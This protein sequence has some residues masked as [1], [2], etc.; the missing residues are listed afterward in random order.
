V[1]K[2]RKIWG[3]TERVDVGEQ[4]RSADLD[5][6]ISTD[7]YK[8]QEITKPTEA[9]AFPPDRPVTNLQFMELWDRIDRV[10]MEHHRAKKKTADQIL[11]AMGKKP[12]AQRLGSVEW[13]VRVMWGLLAAVTALAGAELKTIVGYVGDL[14]EAQITMRRLVESDALKDAK[15]RALE[16]TLTQSVQRL[17]DYNRRN[18]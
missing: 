12:P 6:D 16:I 8:D 17:D 4:Y 13:K 14:R 15:L 9:L 2:R 1:G 7:D 18:Q 11:E 10:K 3:D 5:D